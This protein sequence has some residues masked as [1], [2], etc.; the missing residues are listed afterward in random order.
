MT[1]DA[2]GLLNAVQD[3]ALASGWFEAVNG[4]EPKSPP[5]TSGLTAAVWVQRITPAVGGSGLNATSIRLELM[6][7][8]YAGIDQEPADMLDPNMLAALDDLL[9]RYSGDF[10]LDGDVRQVDLLGQFGD[11]LSARAGYMIQGGTEYRVLDITLPLIVND[12]WDQEA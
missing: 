4:H 3:H 7:R 10:E 1:L 5:D 12:L 9:G 8:M 2:T 11:P 6:L